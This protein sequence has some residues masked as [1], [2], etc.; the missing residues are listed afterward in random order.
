M[1][2]QTAKAN[3]PPTRR[4]IVAAARRQWSGPLPDPQSLGDFD[5]IIPYGAERIMRMSE[6]EQDHRIEFENARLNIMA[7]D[8]R[9]GHYLGLIISICAIIGAVYTASIG[10]H[11]TVSVA[12]VGVPIL[13][14]VRAIVGNKTERQNHGAE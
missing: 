12:L 3:N 8:T 13:G 7:G 10:A 5:A 6:K 1:A 4:Q 14:I 2:K 9:R 11:W